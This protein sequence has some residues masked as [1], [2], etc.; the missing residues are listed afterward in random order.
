[1]RRD[2][3]AG[4]RGTPIADSFLTTHCTG[5]SC[6]AHRVSSLARHGRV[7]PD[8]GMSAHSKRGVTQPGCPSGLGV[9]R[10]GESISVYHT[11]CAATVG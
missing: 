4:S 11:L 6:A 7:T 10:D 3:T 1:M 9:A 8:R 5:G 2:R